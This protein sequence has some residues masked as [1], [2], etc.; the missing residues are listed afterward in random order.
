MRRD[1]PTGSGRADLIY[2]MASG[3]FNED[4]KVDI[5]TASSEGD[6]ISVLLI[7]TN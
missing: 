6:S 1:I 3:D 2:A 5:V 7:S 4:G